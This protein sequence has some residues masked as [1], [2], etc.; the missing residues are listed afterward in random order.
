MKGKFQFRLLLKSLMSGLIFFLLLNPSLNGQIS[1]EDYIKEYKGLAIKEMK[2]TGIP[3]S[4]TL[5]QA[6]LESDNG[7]SK[8]ARKANNHFGIKCHDNWNGK[9]F[10]KDDD[11]SHECFRKYKSVDESYFD[12]SEFLK[13]E[14]YQ[15]LF[16]LD[17]KDYKGWARGLKKS[18]YATNPKYSQ[19]LITVIEE[20]KLYKFDDINN[21]E[22]DKSEKNNIEKVIDIEE[23]DEDKI[24]NVS[25]NK[26]VN[27]NYISIGSSHEI[28]LNNRVKYIIAKEGDNIEDLNKEL[29]LMPWQ[30]TK[31]NE[32]TPES[33]L[34][35]GDILYL[36]PKRNKG[37]VGKNIH[38]VKNG[39]TLYSISQQY[40]IKL[41]KLMEI[42]LIIEDKEIKEGDIIYL[43]EKTN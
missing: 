43:R 13:R 6:L 29:D 21:Q 26:N 20:N 41:N 32:I 12:H 11:E 14:R 27:T 10:H 42:N 31:Y 15:S 40:A 1:R 24:S 25:K 18:G 22:I 34:K 4:I 5:G 19:L 36:Q 2:R 33:I 16:E 39:E 38:H 3:A 17:S 8:L 9:K 7:N 28:K 37:E 23:N 30:L 35:A